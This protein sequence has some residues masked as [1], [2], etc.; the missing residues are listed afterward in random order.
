MATRQPVAEVFLGRRQ[1]YI[2][3]TTGGLLFALAL[4][5]LLAAAV[6]YAS[7][8]AFA[9]TFLLAAVGIVSMLYTHRNLLG[10]RVSA[11]PSYPVFAGD[12]A[13]FEV[14]LKN[15]RAM[16]RL[17]ISLEQGK[18]ELGTV[19]LAPGEQASLRFEVPTRKRGYM[20][21][22]PVTVS[23]R[24]PLGLLRAWSRQL[25]LGQRC[26]V[27]PQ[28]AAAGTSPF[29]TDRHGWRDH[30]RDPE[31]DDFLGLREF[32]RGDSPRHVSW[33][34]AARGRGMLSKQF[35]G[36]YRSSVWLDWER[37]TDLD[38]ERRLRQLCRWV[39]E[40]EQAG[41]LYGLRLPQQI[42]VPACGEEHQHRCLAALA[43]FPG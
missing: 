22:P 40:C 41:V 21:A 39:L 7:A 16:L 18:S 34:A 5:V 9:L 1:L 15:D 27:Y 17:A 6:N 19:D 29:G 31:G 12:A 11:R 13:G 4:A 20:G 33:K 2:L 23:T 14:S 25:Q 43:L 28:P 36:G 30:G 10:L 24:F 32:R 8:L 38:E 3:P 35:G 26:L 37:L 42:L